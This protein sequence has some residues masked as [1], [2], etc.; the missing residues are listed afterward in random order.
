MQLHV[1]MTS[2]GIFVCQFR[3]LMDSLGLTLIKI[4]SLQGVCTF[5]PELLAK[6]IL[7][8]VGFPEKYLNSA[9]P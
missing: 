8:K 7:F 5:N 4:Q 9:F 6:S 1:H 2:A 3:V